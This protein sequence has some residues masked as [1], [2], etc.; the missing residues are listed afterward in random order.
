MVVTIFWAWCHN[1]QFC[2]PL[3]FA[4]DEA[5]KLW[6]WMQNIKLITDDMQSRFRINICQRSVTNHDYQT[7]K[8]NF[9]SARQINVNRF[10]QH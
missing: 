3:Y 2:L 7:E 6:K 9:N 5:G 10:S 8:Y 4:V 1:L